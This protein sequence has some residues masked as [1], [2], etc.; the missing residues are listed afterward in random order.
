MM[1][2]LDSE[3]NNENPQAL[4]SNDGQGIV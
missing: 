2:V 1:F 4:A 3:K